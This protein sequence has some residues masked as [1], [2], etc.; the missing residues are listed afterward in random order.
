MWKDVVVAYL[1]VKARDLPEGT[2][3]DHKEP[4]SRVLFE[5]SDGNLTL[6]MLLPKR[7]AFSEGHNVITQ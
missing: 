6:N 5:F 7:W 4:K 3:G 2:E 1:L